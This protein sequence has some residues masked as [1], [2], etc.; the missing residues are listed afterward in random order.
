VEAPP[1]GLEEHCFGS[2]PSESRFH[3]PCAG[4]KAS[5]SASVLVLKDGC[6]SKREFQSDI[7]ANACSNSQ[8][9]WRI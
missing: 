4:M 5:S 1:D 9:L 6:L 8:S 3:V 2:S 7:P